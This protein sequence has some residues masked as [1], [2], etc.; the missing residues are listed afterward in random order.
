VIKLASTL[1]ELE[2]RAN[3]HTS[4]CGSIVCIN[5]ASCIY[6][7][8][9]KPGTN[10]RILVPVINWYSSH[11]LHDDSVRWR[12]YRPAAVAY[13]LTSGHGSLQSSPVHPAVQTQLLLLVSQTP[14]FS[15]KSQLSSQLAPNQPWGQSEVK[16][17]STLPWVV[18]VLSNSCDLSPYGILW[19]VLR[20]IGDCTS[21]K[22]PR[23]VASWH[24]GDEPTSKTSKLISKPKN[25]HSRHNHCDKLLHYTI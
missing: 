19:I 9:Y 7:S 14:S 5:G 21:C 16:N 6:L 25:S 18:F 23:Q 15:H 2:D 11:R 1:V 13:T 17:K 24:H 20:E 4:V 10:I 12:R 3:F 22:L 8:Y